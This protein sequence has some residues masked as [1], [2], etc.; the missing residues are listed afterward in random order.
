MSEA[1]VSV[2]GYCQGDADHR[3]IDCDNRYLA[4]LELERA[5]VIGRTALDL[6]FHIDRRINAIM[7]GRLASGGAAFSITKRYVRGDGSLFWVTNHVAPVAGKGKARSCAICVPAYTPVTSAGLASNIRAVRC[8]GAAFVAAKRT[9]DE[10]IFSAPAVEIL[11]KLYAAE[12]EGRS[13]TGEGLAH[14][15]GLST[16][17]ALRWLLALAQRKLIEVE[18]DAPATLTAHFRIGRRCELA[19][20]EIIALSGQVR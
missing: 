1:E 8:L 6:T 19:F 15:L 7:L 14:S 9:I 20:D 12:L 13:M 4:I 18:H 16:T 10:K 2:A 3:I 17:V 11:L 5:E